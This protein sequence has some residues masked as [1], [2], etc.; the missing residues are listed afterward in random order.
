VRLGG[1]Y[2]TGEIER[3]TLRHTLLPLDGDR[4]VSDCLYYAREFDAEAWI[5]GVPDSQR[6]NECHHLV[7]AAKMLQ[8]LSST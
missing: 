8:C 4:D 1:Y 7:G 5:G 2:T 3:K 6:Q